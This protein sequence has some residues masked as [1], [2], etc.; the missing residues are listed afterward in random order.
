MNY[1]FQGITSDMLLLLE[2]NRFHNNKTFYEEHKKEIN[3]G[4]R[5]QMGALTL[6]L[7]ESLYAI[8]ANMDVNPKRVSR[9]RRDTRFTKDKTKN[10]RTILSWLKF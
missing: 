1:N 3:E 10:E 2:M 8:D 5:K 6:D 4:V 9:I 7:A